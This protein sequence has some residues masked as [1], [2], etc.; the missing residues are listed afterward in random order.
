MDKGLMGL[1]MAMGLLKADGQ[2]SN[3][4]KLFTKASPLSPVSA[5][6]LPRLPHTLDQS[7]AK[8]RGKEV[9]SP[10]KRG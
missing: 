9:E 5:V 4:G 7:P 6:Q 10:I 1:S 8:T 3:R 2:T